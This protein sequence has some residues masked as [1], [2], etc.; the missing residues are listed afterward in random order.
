MIA[1]MDVTNVRADFLDDTGGLMAKD[2]R[3]RIA[4][5]AIDDF[6]VSVAQSRHA[7]AHDDIGGGW[8]GGGNLF[9]RERLAGLVQ[10]SGAVLQSHGTAYAARLARSA[11]IA[12]P[13][14]AP[15]NSH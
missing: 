15:V 4:Q 13:T 6:E 7:N 12:A 1:D 5:R 9:D 10:N 2:H 3:Q 11:A 14:S 8:G